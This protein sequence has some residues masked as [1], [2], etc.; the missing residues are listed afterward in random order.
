[1]RDA[2]TPGDREAIRVPKYVPSVRV[3]I[4]TRLE[5]KRVEDMADTQI[6]DIVGLIIFPI[7]FVIASIIAYKMRKWMKRRRTNH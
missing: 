4:G 3:P 2:I 5:E 7:A 1:V 6:F